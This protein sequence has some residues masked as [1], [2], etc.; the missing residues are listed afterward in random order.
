MLQLSIL[1][2]KLTVSESI[3]LK[4]DQA[5]CGS[6]ILAANTPGP[7]ECY[8]NPVTYNEIQKATESLWVNNWPTL[9]DKPIRLGSYGDPAKIPLNVLKRLTS[10]RSYTGYTHRWRTCRES[11]SRYLMASID[12]TDDRELARGKGFRTFRIL[13]PSDTL[14][15]TEILC[16]NM[17]HKVQ[18]KDCGLC[19]GASSAKNIGIPVHGPANK[20]ANYV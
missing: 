12:H 17:T 9:P 7:L 4:A 8:V 11:Y 10:D 20:V 14:D 2:T 13:G 18:C 19:N 1:P 15:S 5:Q 16:P 6:C 3:R